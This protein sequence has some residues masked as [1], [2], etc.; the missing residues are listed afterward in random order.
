MVCVPFVIVRMGADEFDKYPLPQVADLNDQ[1]VLVSCDVKHHPIVFHGIRVWKIPYD[2]RRFTPLR[3]F[4]NRYP[5]L[6]TRFGVW[7]LLVKLD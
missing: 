2:I 1:P 7:M 3:M 5:G 4:G 6:D